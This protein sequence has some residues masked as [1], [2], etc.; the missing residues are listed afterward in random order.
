MSWPLLGGLVGSVA[1]LAVA[2]VLAA[3]RA[4]AVV[5]V[6]GSSMTPRY[7]HGDRVLVRRRGRVRPG[8][9]VVASLP[10]PP[11]AGYGVS[12]DPLASR[13]LVIKRVAAVPGDA[14]P[15]A[16]RARVAATGDEL[17]PTG[18]LVLLGDNERSVDSRTVGYF[19][20]EAVLAVVVRDLTR[21]RR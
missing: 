9:V 17:V 12:A 20:A 18:R 15:A 14:V 16:V 21:R 8:S 3:R 10:R 1:G 7:R 11:R 13:G 4:F 19:P 5:T 6:T 2:A